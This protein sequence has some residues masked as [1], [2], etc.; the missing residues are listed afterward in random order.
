MRIMRKIVSV[1]VYTSAILLLLFLSVDIQN[2]EKRRN[3]HR[4]ENL[5]PAEIAAE[6]WQKQLPPA[7]SMAPETD[8]IVFLLKNRPQEAFLQYGKK[9]GISKTWY[10]LVK[11]TGVIISVEEEF[12]NVKTT[13]SNTIRLAIDFIFG[14]AVR[15]GSGLV[16]IDDFV[17]MTGFNNV[18][19]ELN[20]KVKQE[21]VPQ[22]K[23]SLKAGDNIVFA[24]AFEINE[25]S[26]L[27]DS[28][29]L[30]PVSFKKQ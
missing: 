25:D 28:L 21:V 17:N 22:M 16:N 9:L 2:L 11:G 14:N 3:N 4:P 7:C 5:T 15:D 19:V 8:S 1:A 29:L 26:I 30:I 27:S 18:S 23:K 12:I 24:G 10:F 13:A 6:I 20:K